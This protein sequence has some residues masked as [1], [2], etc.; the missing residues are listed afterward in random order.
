[1]RGAHLPFI[2]RGSP[3]RWLN[4]WSLWRPVRRQTYGYRPSRRATP[5][6]DRY[7][8][9]LFGDRRTCANNLPKVVTWQRGTAGSQAFQSNPITI[10]LPGQTKL[11]HSF[12]SPQTCDSKNRKKTWLN[13]TKQNKNKHNNSQSLQFVFS[14]PT[15]HFIQCICWRLYITHELNF[16]FLWHHI[17]R[18]CETFPYI[19]KQL[20]LAQ[21]R[22]V[23]SKT[24]KTDN[25]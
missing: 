15:T 23:A 24:N 20:A 19:G 8:T 7:Q 11:T 6:L 13:L 21:T 22:A 10:T 18:G 2:G 25:N 16:T 4:H 9:I 5:S 1:M 3:Y 14:I 12:T 17:H